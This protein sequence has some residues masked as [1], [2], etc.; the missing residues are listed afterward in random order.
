ME[1]SRRKLLSGIAPGAL[2]VVAGCSTAQIADFTTQWAAA[3]AWI[4]QQVQSITNVL[5]TI[6]S[7]AATAAG[8]FGPTY[9]AL[10]AAGSALANTVVATITAVINAAAPPATPAASSKYKAMF[11]GAGVPQVSIGKTGPLPY[12]PGGVPIS[13][14]R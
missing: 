8:L 5:P 10:V 3:Q 7:I 13:V 11:R 2:I 9:E 12:A 4:A 14:V 6:E 1:L